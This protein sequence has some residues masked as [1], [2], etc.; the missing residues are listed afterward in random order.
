M[1][2]GTGNVGLD[3]DRLW[4]NWGRNDGYFHQVFCKIS[5]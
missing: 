5:E 2:S 1:Q 4:R 3:T